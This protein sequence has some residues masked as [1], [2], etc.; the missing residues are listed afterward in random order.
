M[1]QEIIISRLLF[2]LCNQNQKRTIV[3]M[4]GLL[5]NISNLKFMNI[6]AQRMLH[7]VDAN[8]MEPLLLEIF[9]H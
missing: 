4:K 9:D 6:R 7:E 2:S 5:D 8:S 3:E 1:K